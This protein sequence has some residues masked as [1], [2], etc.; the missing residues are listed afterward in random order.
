MEIFHSVAYGLLL[1]GGSASTKLEFKH[2]Q[3]AF[4]NLVLYSIEDGNVTIFAN[5]L[6]EVNMN[7]DE[8]IDRLTD[9][10]INSLDCGF[11]APQLIIYKT[12]RKQLHHGTKQEEIKRNDAKRIAG[13]GQGVSL[14]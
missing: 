10:I 7:K 6:M 1:R 12:E 11:Y 9:C 3:D 8:L 2:R 14:W 5:S 13:L 4:G